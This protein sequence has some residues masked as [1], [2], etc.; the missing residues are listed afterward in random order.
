MKLYKRNKTYWTDFSVNGQRFR[1]SLDTTNRSQATSLAHERIA[2]AKQG[3]L[4][5]KTQS[6]ARLT[7]IEAAEKYL[8]SRKLELQASSLTKETQLLVK[9][10]EYFGPMRLNRINPEQVLA[11]REWRSTTCGPALVNME[12][13]VLRR[14]LKRG[15][16]WH[17]MA[18]DIRPLKEP[19]TI[20]RALTPAEKAA[21]L[22]TAALKPEWQTAFYAAQIALQTGMRGCEIRGLKWS[23]VDL[24]ADTLTIRKSKTAAGVR[25]IPLTRVAFPV[26]VE[27]RKRA[28][29]FGDVLPEHY[30]FARF[31]PVGRFDGKELRE[32]RVSDFDPT[33]P[34]SSWK[35]A[36]RTLTSKAGLPGLRFHDLRHHLITELC[37]SGAS[38]QTIKAI[39]GHVSQRML[40]RYSHIRLDAK[41]QALE[42]L[43]QGSHVTSYDTK[44][45]HSQPLSSQTTDLIGRRVRI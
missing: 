23:D 32:M 37:E 27:L 36:W 10:K 30:I 20:G 6:F 16:L 21:L 12:I 25:T 41:R 31:K 18:D 17:T 8:Q 4:S 26:F 2:Q 28:E 15:K 3:K 11:F 9:L 7:F 1:V 5:A 43:A 38:E 22:E 34:L 24:L 42:A 40:D 45:G 33:Q 14:I 39:A 29:L 44:S 19:E 35:K 13:G